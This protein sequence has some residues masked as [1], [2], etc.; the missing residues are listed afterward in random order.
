MNKTA[1]NIM[2]VQPVL[3]P[4][5]MVAAPAAEKPKPFISLPDPEYLSMCCACCCSRRSIFH[6]FPDCIGC[7]S[8][9]ECLC[10]RGGNKC[11]IQT[12]HLALCS[13]SPQC[14]ACDNKK[15]LQTD[16]CCG[17]RDNCVCLICCRCQYEN[18]CVIPSTCIKCGDQCC[19]LEG[20]CALPCDDDVP[21]QIG[22]CGVYCVGKP[23][24][25]PPQQVVVMMAPT[26]VGQPVMV[27][28]QPMPANLMER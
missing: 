28:Q 21:F 27:V 7:Q 26:A 19:C 1:T 5:V 15:D 12:E 6:K 23:A 8:G 10:C 11:G 4:A 20:R 2:Q 18:V 3:Q 25:K 9:G 14:F 16:G 13:S 22:C 24:P 17:S